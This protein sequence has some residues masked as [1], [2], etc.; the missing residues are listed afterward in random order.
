MNATPLLHVSVI[1]VEDHDDT[2]ELEV[3]ALLDAGALVEGVATVAD[4]VRLMA[5]AVPDVVVVDL[6]LPGEDGYALLRSIRQLASQ[7]RVGVIAAT[8]HALD[9][10][11]SRALAAGFDAFLAKPFAPDLLVAVVTALAAR[12]AADDA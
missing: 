3:F 11:R 1:V 8:A 12:L 6:D 7:K 4:A 10:D 2:R 5:V 9:T